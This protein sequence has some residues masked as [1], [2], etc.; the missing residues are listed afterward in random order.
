MV[1][2]FTTK[3]STYKQHLNE[4]ISFYR[5]SAGFLNINNSLK[6]DLNVDICVFGGGLTGISTALNLFCTFSKGTEISLSTVLKLIVSLMIFLP[7]AILLFKPPNIDFNIEGTPG[8]QKTFSIL[9]PG[10][11]LVGF[12]IKFAFSGIHIIF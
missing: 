4:N 1:E 7:P 11:P 9:N 6:K 3:K 8:K 2:M 5:H 10:A 12:K